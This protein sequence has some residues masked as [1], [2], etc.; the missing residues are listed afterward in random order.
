MPF[1]SG[2]KVS[3]KTNSS[4]VISK[5]VPGA[6]G[7]SVYRTNKQS[8]ETQWRGNVTATKYEDKD[9]SVKTDYEYYVV[10]Q[11]SF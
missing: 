9:Y 8:G 1:A 10:A 7:Y 4:A 5:A 6:S 3:R 2:V 11:S